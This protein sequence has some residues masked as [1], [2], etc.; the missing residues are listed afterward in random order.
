[1][2]KIKDL[3]NL[4]NKYQ[5]RYDST[6]KKLAKAKKKSDSEKYMKE[7]K[8]AS[9]KLTKIKESMSKGENLFREMLIMPKEN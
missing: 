1:M 8:D 3:E 9:D 4:R 6:K 5:K 7:M 2:N